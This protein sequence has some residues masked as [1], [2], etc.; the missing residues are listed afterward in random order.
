V[1]KRRDVRNCNWQLDMESGMQNRKSKIE[2][3]KSIIR[4]A[5][6]PDSDDA[7]MF[8][9]LASGQINTAPE[10]YEHHL[11]D[12]ET[13]NRAAEHGKYEVTALSF[14]AYAYV[15]DRYILLPHGASFGDGYGPVLVARQFKPP[16]AL[17]SPQGGSERGGS[18]GPPPFRGEGGVRG[19]ATQEPGKVTLR[20]LAPPQVSSGKTAGASSG[21]GELVWENPV[22]LKVQTA[23]SAGAGAPPAKI[24]S[25]SPEKPGLYELAYQGGKARFAVNLDPKEPD[26]RPLDTALFLSA[27]T[28]PGG[29]RHDEDGSAVGLAPAAALAAQV[30]IEAQQRAW[31][32]IILGVLGLLGCEMWLATRI[33]R[34]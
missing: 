15:A 3:R 34:A 27:V 20:R 8:Y 13:L 7:F 25:F 14:H 6:S 31:W 21:S 5:H 17:P 2:N 26:L 24:V 4:L 9:A 33:G 12:I 1:K 22:E 28:R 18:G 30:R 10:V 19:L 32:Y 16:L 23:G 11:A 29:V